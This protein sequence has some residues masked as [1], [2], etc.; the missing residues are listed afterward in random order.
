MAALTAADSGDALAG[1]DSGAGGE[2]LAAA[3]LFS[4]CCAEAL[5]SEE[6][7]PALQALSRA[8]LVAEPAH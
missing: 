8:A 7:C 3:P 1:E 2:P 4:A 5:P 6:A